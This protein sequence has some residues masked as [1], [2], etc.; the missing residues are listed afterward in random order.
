MNSTTKTIIAAVAIVAAVAF[1]M[2]YFVVDQ[3]HKA[4]VLR[5]GDINRVV[6]EPGLYFKVPFADTVTM[7]DNRIMIWENNDRP[8]QDVASQV[9]IVD[10]ITLARIKDARLFRETLGADLLQAEARVA[11]RLDAALRQTYGRRSFDAALSSDRGTMMREIRD[12]LREEADTLGIEI[13]DVR[14]RRTDLS[15]NVLEQTYR[16]MESERKALA[17]DI[18]SQGEASKTRMNAETDRT[19]TEKLAQAKKEAQ[20]LRGQGDAERNKVYAQAFEQDPEFFGFYRSMQAYAKSLGNSGTTMV[21]SP[22]SEFFRYFGAQKAAGPAAPP[23]LAVAPAQVPAT[24]APA[25][26]S[27]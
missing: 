6:E 7:I 13:V 18:R 1:Y 19:V 16:R 17:Q 26:P 12:Q 3:K 23:P 20:I 9:Y 24:P 15:E 25:T 8:V 21:L 4:L 2:S 11:A 22:D 14:V 10:A 27:P 5:F